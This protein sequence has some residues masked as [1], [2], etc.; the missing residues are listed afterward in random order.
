MLMPSLSWTFRPGRPGR[1]PLGSKLVPDTGKQTGPVLE[2]RLDECSE[3]WPVWQT[4]ILE[5]V[6][7]R[8]L[9][10]GPSE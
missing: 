8:V 4:D 6:L 10:L 3:Y 2:S 9:D 7:G 1:H 5:V